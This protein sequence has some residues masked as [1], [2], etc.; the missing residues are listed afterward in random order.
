MI[1]EDMAV[2]AS[3]CLYD[4]ECYNHDYYQYHCYHYFIVMSSD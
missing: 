4:Y 1:T 2:L 3:S